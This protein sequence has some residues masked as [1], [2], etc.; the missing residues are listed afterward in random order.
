[1][2]GCRFS[3]GKVQIV[4]G[5]I[6]EEDDEDRVE[7][8]GMWDVGEDLRVLLFFLT[9]RVEGEVLKVGFERVWRVGMRGRE[10]WG[11]GLEENGGKRL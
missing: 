4:V 7:P 10:K 1:M 9:V 3:G 11:G 5:G 8:V 6:G 2:Q